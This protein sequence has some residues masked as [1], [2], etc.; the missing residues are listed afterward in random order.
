MSSRVGRRSFGGAFPVH[1]SAAAGLP[2]AASPR[3]SERMGAA[4]VALKSNHVPMLS[5]PP[6]ALDVIRKAA[7]AVADR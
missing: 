7:A 6:A 4:T 5:Q 1:P 3:R 2:T